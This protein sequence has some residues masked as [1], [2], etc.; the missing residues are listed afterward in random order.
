L[1]N[2]SGDLSIPKTSYAKAGAKILPFSISGNFFFKNLSR[3]MPISISALRSKVNA[4][5]LFF[6]QGIFQLKSQGVVRSSTFLS[7]AIRSYI[8]QEHAFAEGGKKTL[9]I[10]NQ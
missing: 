1:S 2:N 10:K 8:E 5:L 9:A 3:F 6:L 7:N 4:R